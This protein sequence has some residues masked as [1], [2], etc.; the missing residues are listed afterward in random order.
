[1][2]MVRLYDTAGAAG[3]LNSND[4]I[5]RRGATFSLLKSLLPQFVVSSLVCWRV[6]SLVSRQ[7]LMNWNAFINVLHLE[8]VLSVLRIL[9]S[10]WNW[11]K[12]C[13]L[14]ENST[15]YNWQGCIWQ[16]LKLTEMLASCA[17]E[18]LKIS[19]SFCSLM[20]NFV[21][22]GQRSHRH[23]LLLL[24]LSSSKYTGCIFSLESLCGKYALFFKLHASN[25]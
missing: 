1:M 6:L 11:W 14:N 7:R 21:V 10:I 9:V 4:Q 23:V 2:H 24:F 20:R 19:F 16:F 15:D 3:S 17:F 8:S 18:S 5:K 12:S 22:H 13:V 25:L